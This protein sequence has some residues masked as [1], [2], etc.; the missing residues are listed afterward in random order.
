MSTLQVDRIIP[1]LS[2]S[3][4][5]EGAIQ[6][7]AAT[8]GSNTFIGDQNIQGTLTAS[9]QEGFVL[10]GGVGDVSKLVATSSFGGG[11]GF[12]FTGNAVIT[13]SLLVSGS[14]LIDLE[15]I[16][17]MRATGSVA[18]QRSV[19]A[20]DA[21]FNFNGSSTASLGATQ[22]QNNNGVNGQY[23]GTTFGGSMGVY[24]LSNNT[25]LGLALDGATWTTNWG[26][27]PI[28]YV[29]NTPGDTYE[30]VFGF[31]DKTNY[32]DG[33]VT[34]LKPLD[35]IG[36]T[37]ITGSLTISGSAAVD[38]RVVGNQTISG[39]VLVSG[40][41]GIEKVLTLAGQDPLPANGIGQLAVS[42]SNLYYNDGS[43][44]T[45]IN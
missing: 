1:Y 26:N 12:P 42:G 28:L 39:S 11:S 2:A 14:S 37:T 18:G 45:Q 41:V 10:A 38:L 21:V 35:V 13:G 33:R 32:T 23:L 5:I 24:N 40:S 36:N 22:I 25:E 3:V 43:T 15:V 4:Q 9:I 7:N 30:G 8:T 34:A 16:G 17:V 31:Q 29:N 20:S 6:A 27:G 44:W 19:V